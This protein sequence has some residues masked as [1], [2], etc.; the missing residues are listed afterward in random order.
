MPCFGRRSRAFV[1][2][3]LLTTARSTRALRHLHSAHPAPDA[4]AEQAA[5][6]RRVAPRG[7]V[8][9]VLPMHILSMMI[10]AAVL[11]AA[12]YFGTSLASSRSA[13]PRTGILRIA[14]PT[15]EAMTQG[16]AGVSR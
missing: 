4:N 13:D 11:A 6:P 8:Q 5:R 9:A 16:S 3:P 1:H 2:A 15:A 7:D 10:V 12:A 14:L